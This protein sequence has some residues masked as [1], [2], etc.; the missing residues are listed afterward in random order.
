MLAALAETLHCRPL[1]ASAKPAKLGCGMQHPPLRS[2]GVLGICTVANPS[3]AP[4]ALASPRSARPLRAFEMVSA[5]LHCSFRMSRQM[6]PW[7]LMLGWYTCG[8]W[9][10]IGRPG[11][12]DWGATA[13]YGRY[14]FQRVCW[15]R[16]P[17]STARQAGSSTTRPAAARSARCG[18]ASQRAACFTATSTTQ[19]ATCSRG[20]P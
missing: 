1:C 9:G 8:A 6:L 13:W 7:L 5:G 4:P 3:L 12:D 11:N 18:F 16:Q 2:W 14:A 19:Q 20:S 17:A 10:G 15:D